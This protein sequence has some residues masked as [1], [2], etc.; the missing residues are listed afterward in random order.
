MCAKLFGI[1]SMNSGRQVVGFVVRMVV[2]QLD[3]PHQPGAPHLG[4]R[5]MFGGHRPQLSFEISAHFFH[6]IDHSTRKRVEADEGSPARQEV[7]AFDDD[8]T[9]LAIRF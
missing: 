4:N 8:L 5:R 7:A 6:V 1:L 3:T 9:L 2:L